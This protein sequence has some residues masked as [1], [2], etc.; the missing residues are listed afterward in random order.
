MSIQDTAL[1]IG[2][3]IQI[4]GLVFVIYELSQVNSSIRVTAQASLYQQSSE[5]RSLLVQHP[6]LR[7]YIFDR[8]TIDRDSP[9]YDRARTIA[10]L[11]LNYLEHLVIQRDS[12][13][14]A[15]W[16]AW[17]AFV[18]RSLE[19]S[20]LMQSILD[21]IPQLYTTEL[22]EVYRSIST[23]PNVESVGGR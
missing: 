11:S 10:E 15:D 23:S 1:I 5:I 16:Q 13:R 20:P 6:H 21:D 3:V 2:M 22:V 18:Q 4:I 8:E 7:K 17:N 9:D 19:S 14:K 12:L